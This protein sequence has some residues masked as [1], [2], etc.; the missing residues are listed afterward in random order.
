[1]LL[2][3]VRHAIAFDRDPLRWPDD[4]QR[5][6]TPAGEKRFQRAAQGLHRLGVQ[7][8]LVLSSRYVRAWQTAEILQ[9]V[10]GWPAPVACEALESGHDPPAILEA[11]RQH[12]GTTALA[13]VGHEP[14]LHELVSYLLTGDAELAAVEFRKGSVARLQLGAGVVPGRATLLWQATPKLLRAM[15]R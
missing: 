8:D 10:A 12:H 3:V 14:T 5:P 11:L 9:R 4:R 1:M 15:R 2:H 6:L 7:V 13:V